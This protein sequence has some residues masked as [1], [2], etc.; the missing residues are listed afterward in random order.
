ME[1]CTV[2]RNDKHH[3]KIH[4]VKAKLLDFDASFDLQSK[5]LSPFLVR[6]INH[7]LNYSI[8]LFDDFENYIAC[9]IESIAQSI[10]DEVAMQD[11]FH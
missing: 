3:L 1:T 11:M 10:L 5:S 9:L 7:V 6:L 4:N 8:E 2:P